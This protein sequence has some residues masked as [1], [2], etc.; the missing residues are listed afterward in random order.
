[1]RHTSAAFKPVTWQHSNPLSLKLVQHLM[2][3]K[4]TLLTKILTKIIAC[5]VYNKGFTRCSKY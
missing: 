1:M 4:E 3:E 5:S 2:R